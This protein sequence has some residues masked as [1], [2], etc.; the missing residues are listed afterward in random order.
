MYVFIDII[1]QVIRKVASRKAAA[2]V[3]AHLQ[4]QFLT[5][6]LYAA[7]SSRPGQSGRA[8]G[9]IF[10]AWLCAWTTKFR[11]KQPR[12]KNIVTCCAWFLPGDLNAA[13]TD[14]GLKPRNLKLHYRRHPTNPLENMIGTHGNVILVTEI[15]QSPLITIDVKT[16]R[17]TF[18]LTLQH[19]EF[20]ATTA[21]NSIPDPELTGP[22]ANNRLYKSAHWS[23]LLKQC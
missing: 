11:L 23:L 5:G 21:H 19:R 13:F 1:I 22:V 14:A 20:M 7:I 4:S 18:H 3:D 17:G 15:G 10:E 16:A 9:Y 8:D 2:P 12:I 6:R